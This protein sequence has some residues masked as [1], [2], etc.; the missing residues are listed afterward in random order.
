MQQIAF[1]KISSSHRLNDQC[2]FFSD[3]YTLLSSMKP[4][5]NDRTGDQQHN[6]I[7]MSSL[8]IRF[9]LLPVSHISSGQQQRGRARAVRDSLPKADS[10]SASRSTTL[11]VQPPP[12][13]SS[14][15]SSSSS[16]A[17]ASSRKRSKSPATKNTSASFFG[18]MS[19]SWF[20]K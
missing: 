8:S 2:I 18:S 11:S 9:P 3:R 19:S 4:A 15:S 1:S 16:T 7:R 12:A 13:A 6:V 14:R 20:G 17:T 5:A 10:S